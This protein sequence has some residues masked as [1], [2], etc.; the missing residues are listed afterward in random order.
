MRAVVI[1]SPGDRHAG[2]EVAL[3]TTPVPIGRAPEEAGPLG[4]DD[5]ELSRSHAVLEPTARGYQIRDLGS[6]SGTFVGGTPTGAETLAEGQ[7]FRVGSHLIVLR[8]DDG[9]DDAAGL[10]HAGPETVLR[11]V[12]E[13][14]AANPRPIA[15]APDAAEALVIHAW[16]SEEELTTT[17]TEAAAH[18]AEAGTLDLEHLPPSLR[19]PLVMRKAG[20]MSLPPV[21]VP[22]SLR[23]D[24]HGT[25][26]AA[27][28]QE[29][30]DQFQGDTHKVAEF[31]ERD[32]DVI[33]AW[34][35]E[36]GLEP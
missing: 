9:P 29:V 17:V 32:P 36:H 24:R 33:T 35:R 11:R 12:S 7:V 3:G 16:H 1:Y 23:I 26:S 13:H 5:E 18:A 25:P 14:L 27:E 2:L 6:R 34:C 30:L 20:R 19:G 10:A 15:L 31:F 8:G 22:M 28:L 4:L 21:R